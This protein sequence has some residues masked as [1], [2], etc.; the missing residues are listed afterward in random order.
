MAC[1]TLLL[2]TLI[3]IISEDMATCSFQFHEEASENGAY[4]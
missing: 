2:F 3:L 1:T 4:N